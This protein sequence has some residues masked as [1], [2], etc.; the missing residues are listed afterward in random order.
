MRCIDVTVFTST[1]EDNERVC[2]GDGAKA[3]WVVGAG[4]C[5]ILLSLSSGADGGGDPTQLW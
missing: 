5:F 1:G 3:G 4:S 2:A